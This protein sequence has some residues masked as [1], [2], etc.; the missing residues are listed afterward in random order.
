[1]ANLSVRDQILTPNSS[2]PSSGRVGKEEEERRSVTTVSLCPTAQIRLDTE[3]C[4]GTR[5]TATSKAQPRRHEQGNA[6]REERGITSAV[7]DTGES[8]SDTSIGH[9]P[10]ALMET[11]LARDDLRGKPSLQQETKGARCLHFPQETL[12]R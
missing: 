8:L 6:M 11:W 10:P 3:R 5:Q 4:P 2:S 1:M 9:G 7:Q 12:K